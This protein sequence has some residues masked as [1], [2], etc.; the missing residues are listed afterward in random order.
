MGLDTMFGCE[1]KERIGHLNLSSGSQP[2][3]Q[4][5]SFIGSVDNH[6]GDAKEAHEGPLPVRC[7]HSQ[8]LRPPL[9]QHG[10]DVFGSNCGA[11]PCQPFFLFSPRHQVPALCSHI[12]PSDSPAFCGL[13]AASQSSGIK[14]VQSTPTSLLPSHT[15]ISFV[16]SK[17]S[18]IKAIIFILNF[19]CLHSRT[20][21]QQH[22]HF[23]CSHTSAQGSL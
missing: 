4:V 14:F 10:H 12:A 1:W 9:A 23:I 19:F 7:V 20:H 13:A 8:T 6:A 2:Q 21:S 18:Q 22:Y 3:S 15:V 11:G 17:L 5:Q 16:E